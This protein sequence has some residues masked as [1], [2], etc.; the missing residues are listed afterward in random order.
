[1]TSRVRQLLCETDSSLCGTP[2]EQ[3]VSSAPL[4]GDSRLT[5][6]RI[7]GLEVTKGP[8]TGRRNSDSSEEKERER[9]RADRAATE[10]LVE[11]IFGKLDIDGNDKL[12]QEELQDEKSREKLTDGERRFV[13]W[14]RENYDIIR[15]AS[16]QGGSLFRLP[17]KSMF[18][19]DGL[20]HGGLQAA[21]QLNE[22]YRYAGKSGYDWFRAN[23]VG[24]VY[25]PEKF[26]IGAGIGVVGVAAARYLPAVFPNLR[27]PVAIAFAASIAASFVIERGLDRR[28]NRQFDAAH[29]PQIAKMQNDLRQ[30]NLPL[31]GPT[32]N[33]AKSPLKNPNRKLP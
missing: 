12:S 20:T 18:L 33:T 26:A 5:R 7:E 23:Y 9:Y 29:G 1:M 8:K 6:P 31:A 30:L 21:A 19:R 10:K 27:Y 17:T 24:S 11:S 15:E 2:A 13:D 25:A 14:S 22:T 32:P 3:A 28:L 4:L 16:G